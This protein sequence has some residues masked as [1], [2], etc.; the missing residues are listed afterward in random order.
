MDADRMHQQLNAKLQVQSSI[1]GQSTAQSQP[2]NPTPP[3]NQQ[4]P[5]ETPMPISRQLQLSPVH[6]PLPNPYD[7]LNR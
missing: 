6:A 4:L 2:P 7:I 5:P 3:Q 1:P